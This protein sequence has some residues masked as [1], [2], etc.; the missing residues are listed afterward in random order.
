MY[1]RPARVL[2]ELFQ[3]Q[4]AH[5]QRRRHCLGREVM[6]MLSLVTRE[7]G[8]QIPQIWPESNRRFPQTRRNGRN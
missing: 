1:R 4:P 6:V 7:F 5:R 2:W 3:Q 8:F